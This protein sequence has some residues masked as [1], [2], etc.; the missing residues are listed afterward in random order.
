MDSDLQTFKAFE[1][2][3]ASFC[4]LIPVLLYLADEGNPSLRCSISDYVTIKKSYL[5]GML[6][7]MAAMLFM[8]NGAVYFRQE[9][10]KNTDNRAG[11]WYNVIL[12]LSL[13]MV[14]ILPCNVYETAHLVFA[15]IFFIGNAVVTGI[16]TKQY[17]KT[18]ITLAILTLASFVLWALGLFSLLWAEWVSLIVIAVHFI[19]ETLGVIRFQLQRNY[20]NTIVSQ[21][22]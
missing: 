19:L 7:C 16:F 15:A 9:K 21:R 8:F 14:I 17:R 5:F 2:L 6:L 13:L 12:G 4:M 11:K 1:I 10:R 18:G 3:L 20:S 22:S